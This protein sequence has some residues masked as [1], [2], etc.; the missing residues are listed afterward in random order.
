[1]AY[2]RD[3]WRKSCLRLKPID[4]LSDIAIVRMAIDSPGKVPGQFDEDDNQEVLKGQREE[5]TGEWEFVLDA[6]T[7]AKS[8]LDRITVVTSSMDKAGNTQNSHPRS[9]SVLNS[10]FEAQV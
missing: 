2:A 3:T 9:K 8:S 7:T 4:T 1:M 10:R 5:K 6:E